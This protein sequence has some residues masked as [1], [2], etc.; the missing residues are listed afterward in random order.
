MK[1]STS[2]VN[3]PLSHI[4]PAKCTG[5]PLEH[6]L[7]ACAATGHIDAVA[8]ATQAARIHGLIFMPV[9]CLWI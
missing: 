1:R 8:N 6:Q 3:E 7:P 5:L 2:D 9:S 4:T